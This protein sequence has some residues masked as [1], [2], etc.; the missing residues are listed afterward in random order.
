MLFFLIYPRFIASMW[1]KYEECSKCSGK[2]KI[3]ENLFWPVY[4]IRNSICPFSIYI[5]YPEHFYSVDCSVTINSGGKW[6]NHNSKSV[7]EILSR[8]SSKYGNHE[9]KQTILILYAFKTKSASTLC[10]QLIRPLLRSSKQFCIRL[11]YVHSS[12]PTSFR[13]TVGTLH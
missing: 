7:D 12:K 5:R 1:C 10:F 11:R 4:D 2:Q 8:S 9:A 13:C 3:V 6:T